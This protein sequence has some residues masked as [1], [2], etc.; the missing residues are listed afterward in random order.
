M[1]QR[2]KNLISQPFIWALIFPLVFMDICMELYHHICFPLYGIPLIKRSRY[3]RI[4]RHKLHYLPIMQKFGCLYCG[5]ANG[6]IHY[7]TVIAGTTEQYWCNIRHQKSDDDD[8]IQPL[9]HKNFLEYGN[10]EA[11]KKDR[12]K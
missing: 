4:D 3:I 9:H 12:S 1:I 8:F 10:E 2:V 6:L 5:Y 11:Y 7:A